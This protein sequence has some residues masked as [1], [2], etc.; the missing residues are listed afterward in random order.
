MGLDERVEAEACGDL[1]QVRDL[2]V[3]EVAQQEQRRVGSRIT[4]RLEML[5]GGEEPLREERGSRR[6]SGCPEIVP[7][8]AKSLV[9]EH[10]DRSRS[11]GSVGGCDQGRVGIRADVPRR[12]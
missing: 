10:R 12:R 9:H 5:V 7:G 3:V 1:H 2:A 11:G 4:C 6:G 8:A